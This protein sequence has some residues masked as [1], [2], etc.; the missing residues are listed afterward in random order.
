MQ[1]EI[2]K[3]LE[4][5]SNFYCGL[6]FDG[7]PEMQNINRSNSSTKIDLAFFKR[8][9][10]DQEIKMTISK[11]TLDHIYEGVLYLERL[12]FNVSCNLAYGIDW[13]DETYSQILE[14]ELMKL[15]DYYL[16]NPQITPCRILKSNI[17]QLVSRQDKTFPY[18]GAGTAL[19]AYDIDGKS[20][21]CQLFMPISCGIEKAG[22]SENIKFHRGEIPQTQVE[23]KC[24]KCVVKNIC[25]TCFGA[26][27]PYNVTL[28]KMMIII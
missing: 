5:Q 18:C 6:S 15:I 28:I 3:W 13:S 16:N 9:Y 23:Q 20:Y 7:T 19:V 17:D 1:G 25:P 27:Y 8:Y 10:P 11:Y 24:L 21:P 26:N 4:N 14:R 12:G 2:K 22:N